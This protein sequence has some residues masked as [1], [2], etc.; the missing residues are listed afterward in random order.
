MFFRSINTAPARQQMQIE[1]K[2]NERLNFLYELS[3][4]F[5]LTMEFNCINLNTQLT[6]FNPKSK[7]MIAQR[8]L[9]ARSAKMTLLDNESF[10]LQIEDD[11]G[12]RQLIINSKNLKTLQNLTTDIPDL[13]TGCSINN[14]RFLT[15]D[16]RVNN[17][18]N[19]LT[20]MA[21]DYKTYQINQKVSAPLLIKKSDTVILGDIV[22]TSRPI[23]LDNRQI[24]I[25]VSGHSTDYFEV[26]VFDQKQEGEHE[27]VL[28][29]I[30][31]PK[32]YPVDNSCA[33]GKIVA[34]HNSQLLS[35]HSSGEFFQIWK[36]GQCV[37]EWSWRD[38]NIVSD[39]EFSGPTSNIAAMPDGEHLL[40][41]RN[42]Q[43]FLFNI[44]TYQVQSVKLK[45]TDVWDFC[46]CS[47]G[48]ILVS[49]TS[50]DYSKNLVLAI[51]LDCISNYRKIITTVL[52]QHVR[53]D[54]A[55]IINGYLGLDGLWTKDEEPKPGVSCAI[56]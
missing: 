49:G 56:F 36:D 53:K 28:N 25:H 23:M 4:G 43:L 39:N 48:Q 31:Q 51:D 45:N 5:I 7:K 19:Q 15:V 17:N 2:H 41:L 11:K 30:I 18:N 22:Y 9:N 16:V 26:F 40:V 54:P 47:N 52:S 3:N 55:S 44:E 34:L 14:N 6:L 8:T 46:L 13:N 20:L 1:T 33:S 12:S 21:H 10:L 37:K 24:A 32:R 35:Y 42:Y 29:H 50:K 38:T 27:F